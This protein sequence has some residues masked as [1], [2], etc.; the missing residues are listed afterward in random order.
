M[1]IYYIMDNIMVVVVRPVVA[2]SFPTVLRM[3][4]GD[5]KVEVWTTRDLV[6][7]IFNLY[8]WVQMCYNDMGL[9]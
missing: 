8:A 7:M 2:L 4:D 6:D 3:T 9:N 5:S 1:Y